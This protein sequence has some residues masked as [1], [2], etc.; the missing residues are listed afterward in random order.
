MHK[1]IV[2]FRSI[3]KNV[4]VTSCLVGKL[5]SMVTPCVPC[6]T[7]HRCKL[8]VITFFAIILPV[9]SPHTKVKE[10]GNR[11]VWERRD[12]ELSHT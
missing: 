9:V 4:T 3:F 12:E 7:T 10:I 2:N 5:S 1:G 11:K 8:L 6:M